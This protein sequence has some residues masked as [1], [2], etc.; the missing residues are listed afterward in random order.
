SNAEAVS[1]FSLKARRR[2]SYVPITEEVTRRALEKINTSP[3]WIDF[4]LSRHRSIRDGLG[5]DVT[6]TFQEITGRAP[7]TFE[8]FSE[9][10]AEQ[11]RWPEPSPDLG[12][13]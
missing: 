13:R 12:L 9:E 6:S 10:F 7:K 4:T 2:I 1:I 11:L 3:W 5:K 8:E